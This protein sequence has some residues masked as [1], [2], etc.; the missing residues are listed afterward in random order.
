MAAL[1][2]SAYESP[3]SDYGTESCHMDSEEE[4]LEGSLQKR[5]LDYRI[6]PK[7][8]IKRLKCPLSVYSI[9]NGHFFFRRYYDLFGKA[10]FLMCNVFIRH[11]LVVKWCYT[12]INCEWF[13]LT[14]HLFVAATVHRSKILMHSVCSRY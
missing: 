6:V 7:R 8:S 14:L 4:F 10:N 13:V 12:E 2:D 5:C 3:A 1:A 11:F 9:D